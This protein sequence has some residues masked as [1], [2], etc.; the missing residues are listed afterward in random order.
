MDRGRREA[1]RPRGR[2]Y[3]LV[4]LDSSCNCVTDFGGNHWSRQ[5][6][7]AKEMENLLTS[8]TGRVRVAHR[9]N[10]GA[11]LLDFGQSPRDQME[12]LRVAR[13]RSR[14]SGR[15]QKAVT[16][17]R[18]PAILRNLSAGASTRVPLWLRAVTERSTQAKSRGDATFTSNPCLYG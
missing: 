3:I 16:E 11:S 13:H 14:S 10:L 7:I 4:A 6:R 15:E 1:D 5:G 12:N 2:H 8:S 18:S 9:L 17:R